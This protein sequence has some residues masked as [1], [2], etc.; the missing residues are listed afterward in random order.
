MLSTAAATSYRVQATYS[1]SICM[2]TFDYKSLIV[3][4]LDLNI[5]PGH[6][7]W[8]EDDGMHRW[9]SPSVNG[10]ASPVTLEIVAK[11]YTYGNYTGILGGR[12]K[13]NRSF[14][15]RSIRRT[16]CLTTPKDEIFATDYATAV[17]KLGHLVNL[18]TRGG[19]SE[20]LWQK[21][22]AESANPVLRVGSHVFANL[23]AGQPK[24]SRILEVAPAD[25]KDDEQWLEVANDCFLTRL[26]VR[27]HTG[28]LIPE[29]DVQSALTGATVLASFNLKSWRWNKAKPTGF[30]ADLVNIV[31]LARS[32][33]PAPTTIPLAWQPISP[34]PAPTWTVPTEHRD[35]GTA[36][37][38][39][40]GSDC[41][42]QP[43]T[44]P[45]TFNR[46]I[47]QDSERPRLDGLPV[48]PLAG[49]YYDRGG[50]IHVAGRQP[51]VYSTPQA[52]HNASD[53]P[54][55]LEGGTGTV[56][57][58]QTTTADASTA[59]GCSVASAVAV[60]D[61]AQPTAVGAADKVAIQPETP[62]T[63][64]ADTDGAGPPVQHQMSSPATQSG[65]EVQGKGS[66]P[67]PVATPS[68]AKVTPFTFGEEK[69][70]LKEPVNANGKRRSSTQ[71]AKAG[72]SKVART[73]GLAN[74]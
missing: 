44:L 20:H 48:Y 27:D 31:I 51:M 32:D 33:A 10:S 2:H 73:V 7:A 28:R 39:S 14:K 67:M 3:L 6:G 71:N 35:N 55:S 70:P 22:T 13:E 24:D 16:L 49:E 58:E 72:P 68:V 1:G 23:Q 11:V 66:K 41:L 40:L 4:S 37:A 42:P 19:P 62:A 25:E 26:D 50:Q 9:T 64:G 18:Q 57:M 34:L 45:L 46:K 36:A 38:A 53:E 29:L 59:T 63:F 56:L 30:S 61:A 52:D 8:V 5:A 47:V 43:L 17:S 21:G 60:N 65:G 69:Q 74:D 54:G 15:L 12:R